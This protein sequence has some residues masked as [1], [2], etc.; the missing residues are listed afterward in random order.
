MVTMTILVTMPLTKKRTATMMMIAMGKMTM[1][2]GKVNEKKEGTAKKEPT[3][4]KTP[5]EE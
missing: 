5:R 3:D 4:G 1:K 2:R